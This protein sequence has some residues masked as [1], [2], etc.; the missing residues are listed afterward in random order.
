ML[1]SSSTYDKV[2][3]VLPSQMIPLS[4]KNDEWKEK[5][6]DALENTGITQ[7]NDNCKLLENYEMIKGKFIFQHY[8]DDEDYADYVSRLTHELKL[9]S[10][11]RH[12]DI[13]SQV[14]NSLV[15]EQQARAN[16]FKVRSHDENATSQYQRDKTQ[17]LQDYVKN[18]IDTEVSRRLM[19]MGIDPDKQDFSSPEEQQ[20]Y[21]Q[22]KQNLTPPEI[23]QYMQTNW[24]TAAEMW[25]E[26]QLRLDRD[27]FNIH[28]KEKEEFQD[29]LVADRCFRHFYMTSTGYGQ[30]TWNP[31]Y[32][33]YQKEKE[34]KEVENGD[35]V[36]R[37]LW[38]SMNGIINRYGYMMT[39]EQIEMLRDGRKDKANTKWGYAAGTDFL[40]DYIVPYKGYYDFAIYH[41]T[42]GVQ[43]NGELPVLTNRDL[44]I[45]S[46]QPRNHHLQ[47]GYY[48][49]TEAYWVS[50]KRVYKVN[51]IDPQTGIPNIAF[52]DE[53][54]VIPSSFTEVK[55]SIKDTNEPFTYVSTWIPEVWKGIKIRL[56]NGEFK[57]NLYLNVAPLEFQFKSNINPYGAKLPV[58]G[59]IFNNRNSES[60]SVVDL[61]K[62]YQIFHNVCMN[63]AYQIGEREIGRFIVFDVNMFSKEKDWGGDKAWQK[64]MLVAKE[65][66]LVPA[67][68]SPT[69]LRGALAATGGFLPKDFNF[70]ETA[71]MM[72]RLEMADRFEQKAL[73]Q[74]GFNDYRVGNYASTSTAQ[75]IQEGQNAS[76]NQT[77]YLFANFASYQRRCY[78]M[79]LAI[80][81]YAQSQNK[82]I[83]VMYTKSDMSRAFIKLNG[84]D[85]ILADLEVRVVDSRDELEK[86]QMMRQYA[87]E[88]N[89]VGL[90]PV[91]VMEIIGTD[92]T[93]EIKMKVK[94][95][96]QQHMQTEQ[97]NYDLQKQ[98]VDA[99]QQADAAKLE[100]E[101]QHFYDKLRND[102]AI[103]QVEAGT[104]IIASNEGDVPPQPQSQPD[105][106]YLQKLDKEQKA[107]LEQQKILL[108]KQY[109]DKELAFKQ[110]KLTQELEL[111]N[112]K[113][114]VVKAMKKN[115]K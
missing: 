34:V 24:F 97:Q 41:Q 39:N 23:E 43:A 35:F 59:Q 94:A 44:D 76:T 58:C 110:R 11:L 38:L 6:M 17:M 78:E 15:G 99:Q 107:S 9:P 79:N 42:T 57:K 69:N 10:Y 19:D 48:L 45:L 108:D 40:D 12:Y 104:K 49:V 112:K 61:M 51:Y 52:V 80:A 55:S 14:I 73:R 111:E 63:Q 92:S 89:T 20:Q 68:T 46:T 64:L 33:F 74:I 103:A 113:L 67:D 4:E 66:G 72:N 56:K 28:E 106:S 90:D 47:Q 62:P 22:T 83:Q 98:Q 95:A 101:N 50:L 32:T 114:A 18:Q 1:Y 5:V 102:Y 7:Y 26:H 27:R 16:I 29:M 31:V 21:E 8:L 70:D 3:S 13:I 105:N 93:E 96:W 91:A 65:T 85:I 30:E 82:D 37:T 53:N 84:T 88:N 115:N 25:G 81:Q 75:G 60:M 2:T 71:R 86:T 87:L 100:Q 77:E 36:G 54:V 109:K